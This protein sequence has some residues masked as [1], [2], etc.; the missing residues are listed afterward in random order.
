MSERTYPDY[1]MKDGLLYPPA[2]AEELFFSDGK[3]TFIMLPYTSAGNFKAVYGKEAFDT[4]VRRIKESFTAFLCKKDSWMIETFIQETTTRYR[5]RFV[6]V[7]FFEDEFNTGPT[8]T[9]Q[10]GVECT[11]YVDSSELETSCFKIWFLTD[12]NQEQCV[13][14]FFFHSSAILDEKTITITSSLEGKKETSVV[15]R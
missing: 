10:N 15:I 13:S 1:D 2:S 3:S 8:T 6:R 11:S 14:F 12:D 9:S 7:D 5:G 4:L